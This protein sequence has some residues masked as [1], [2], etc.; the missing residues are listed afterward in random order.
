MKKVLSFLVFGLLTSAAAFAGTTVCYKMSKL[1]ALD[2]QD[3]KYVCIVKG[4]DGV[5]SVNTY[6][7]NE[8]TIINGVQKP[9]SGYYGCVEVNNLP[10]FS[11]QPKESLSLG[12]VATT[13]F[14]PKAI[15]CKHGEVIAY[16]EPTVG[17]TNARFIAD[18]L[19]Y[20]IA[21]TDFVPMTLPEQK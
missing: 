16:E 3:F 19:R 21:A 15:L 17:K 20:A 1:D 5:I 18:G 10:S 11:F 6:P 13:I 8:H 12:D 14:S 2:N 4:N 9:I 7:S